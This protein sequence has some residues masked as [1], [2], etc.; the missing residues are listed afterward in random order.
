MVEQNCIMYRHKMLLS[1]HILKLENIYA[2]PMKKRKQNKTKTTLHTGKH[3]KATYKLKR[4]QL[5][6]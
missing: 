2:V 3:K 1:R 5:T 4:Q 6:S